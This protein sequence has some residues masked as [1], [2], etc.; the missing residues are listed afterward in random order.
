VTL[1]D[2]LKILSDVYHTIKYACEDVQIEELEQIRDVAESL[3]EKKLK[4]LTDDS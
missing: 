3:W 1:Y 4:E 2:E